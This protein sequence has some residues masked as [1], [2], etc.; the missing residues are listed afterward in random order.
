MTWR[1]KVVVSILLLVA[2][3]LDDGQWGNEIKHLA[4]HISVSAP[5]VGAA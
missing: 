3:I 5:Q 2:R 4:A 1:E